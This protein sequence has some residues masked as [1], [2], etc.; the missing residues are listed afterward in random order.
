MPDCTPETR[1]FAQGRG[2]GLSVLEVQRTAAVPQARSAC[3]V[4][5]PEAPCR[6]VDAEAVLL[7]VFELCRSSG[8]SGGY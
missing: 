5:A 7:S 1:W 6:G 2:Q 3:S 4:W 8:Y